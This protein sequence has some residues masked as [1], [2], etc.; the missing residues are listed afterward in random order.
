MDQVSNR[1]QVPTGN[2]SASGNNPR[3]ES[4]ASVA[5]EAVDRIADSA[6]AKVDR[7]SGSVHRAVNQTADAASLAADWATSI[8]EQA[9]KAQVT[10][11]DSVCTAIR[12]RPLAT[13]AGGIV[14][15]YLL[16][17]LARV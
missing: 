17:R 3:V 13:L 7:V 4:A 5:H 11:T 6:T 15:G 14:A 8:P 12:A 16:G 9:R 10:M 2:S 1:T